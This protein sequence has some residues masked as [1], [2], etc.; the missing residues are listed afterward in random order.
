VDGHAHEQ[1]P[2][3][4]SSNADDDRERQQQHV[5]KLRGSLP[6]PR[7]PHQR[8]A[9]QHALQRTAVAAA[10]APVLMSHNVSL[11]RAFSRRS[12]RGVKRRPLAVAL[13]HPFS[14][15]VK[16]IGVIFSQA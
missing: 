6:H 14:G 12:R 3:Y 10:C 8:V 9:Q 11:S 4:Y 15:Y 16:L 5:A 1:Q 13:M 7:I 2:E